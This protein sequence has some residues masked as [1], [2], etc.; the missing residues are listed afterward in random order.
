MGDGRSISHCPSPISSE[1]LR[2]AVHRQLIESRDDEVGVGD[3]AVL[4]AGRVLVV[5]EARADLQVLEFSLG[6]PSP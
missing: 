6:A 4:P 3:T 1:Q 2:G 5:A